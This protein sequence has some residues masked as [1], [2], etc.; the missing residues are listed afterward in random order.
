[1][2]FRI[3]LLVIL[4][5]LA[6]SICLADELQT[7]QDSAF[8]VNSAD[9]N[10]SALGVDDTYWGA[11]SSWPNIPSRANGLKV[12]FYVYDP[13]GPDNTTFNYIFYVADYGC[14][15]EV[16]AS[17]SATCGAAQLSHNPIDLSEFNSGA[18]SSIYCWVDTL[19]TITTDWKNGG[20][21]SQNDGGA[22]SVASFIFDR[23]SAK[24]AWCRIYDRSTST[25][26]VYC[27]AYYY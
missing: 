27:V 1:M 16:V 12:K 20:I 17:G 25:M 6:G 5:V 26:V 14:N 11:L 3:L 15:A 13:C 4:L 10:D 21:N 19:G 24:K 9:S 22:D 23:Q 18:P 7:G 2:K 8:L